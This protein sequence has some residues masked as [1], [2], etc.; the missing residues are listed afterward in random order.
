MKIN[1]TVNMHTLLSKEVCDEKGIAVY[2]S[3]LYAPR[4]YFCSYTSIPAF[5]VFAE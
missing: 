4:D 1:V 3:K 5:T 2:I